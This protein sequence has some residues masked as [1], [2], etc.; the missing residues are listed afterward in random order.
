MTNSEKHLTIRSMLKKNM[1]EIKIPRSWLE[2]LIKLS[3]Q[4]ESSQDD[5]L[6]VFAIAELLGYI[7]SAK[8]ILKYNK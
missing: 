4:A 2:G 3:E 7:S 1:D 5:K 8:T 6:K